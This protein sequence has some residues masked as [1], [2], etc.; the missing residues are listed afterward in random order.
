MAE[1]VIVRRPGEGRALLVGGGDLVTYKVRSGETSDAYFCFEVSTTPGFGPPLHEHA[2]RELFYVLE[3]Q[4]EFT[5]QRGDD[6][7]TITGSAGTS[8]A[9]PPNV[10][11]T[12]RNTSDRAAT[13]LFVHQPA[14]LEEFFEE[15]G[16]PVPHAGEVP[17]EVAPPDPG[18]MAAALERNGVR[19]VEP[20]PVG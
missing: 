7:E 15:F 8:V 19:V 9:I 2:Y 18:A 14:A 20:K 1:Q 16:V 5:F 4:Y 12:F 17:A 11:H 10:R 6:L 13:L 3:G